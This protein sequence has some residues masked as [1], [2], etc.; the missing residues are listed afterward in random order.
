MAPSFHL[1]AVAITLM[2]TL[3]LL[4]LPTA[5]QDAPQD[6]LNTHNGARAAV[7]VG[8]VTWDG[9]VAAYAQ[10]YANQRAAAD[11]S[12]VHSDGPYGEN[13]AW[14]SGQ[15]TG[16]DAVRMWGSEW[17]DYDYNSNTCAPGRDCGHYTQIV[18]R[19]TTTIGCAKATCSGG[20]GTFV[21]CNYNPP[22]NWI[23]QRPYAIAV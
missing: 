18:W 23:G 1:L 9:R 4:A 5:A 20:R 12:L 2:G 3:L 8:P 13:I 15:L 16:I 14:G 19:S 11:C 17:V 21:I 22:G 10:S 6:Y 7:G